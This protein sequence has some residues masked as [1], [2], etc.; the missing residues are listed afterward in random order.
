V[1]TA[2]RAIEASNV[3]LGP[4]YRPKNGSGGRRRGSAKISRPI[5]FR[6]PAGPFAGGAEGRALN[7]AL[8]R[9]VGAAAKT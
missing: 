2:I 7:I 1:L 6:R 8:P 9:G 3:P 4:L 5:G